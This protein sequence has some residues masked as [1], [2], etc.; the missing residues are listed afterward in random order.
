M[1]T[2][3]DPQGRPPGMSGQ[4]PVRTPG[5]GGHHH[6]SGAS[7]VSPRLGPRHCSGE[8]Q[9][10]RAASGGGGHLSVQISALGM[11]GTSAASVKH[12]PLQT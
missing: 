2:G 9:R 10:P 3:D 11:R 6:Y 7:R 12:T 8:G 5:G 1:Q 4:E